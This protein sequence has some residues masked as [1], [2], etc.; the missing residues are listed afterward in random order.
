[1]F[2]TSD[3]YYEVLDAEC[4]DQT[5]SEICNNDPAYYQVRF[6]AYSECPLLNVFMSGH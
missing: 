3:V 5:Y 1:M 2:S 4:E 6:L